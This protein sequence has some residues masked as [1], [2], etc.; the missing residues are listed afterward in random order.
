MAKGGGDKNGN[1]STRES[2]MLS[3]ASITRSK[4]G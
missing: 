2:V 1:E 4:K 3:L